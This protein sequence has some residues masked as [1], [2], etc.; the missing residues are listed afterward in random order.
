[1]VG[2]DNPKNSKS[3]KTTRT[4][5]DI[6]EALKELG[7]VGVT[8]LAEHLELPKSTV[9]IHL[10]TLESKEYVVNDNGRYAIGCRFLEFGAK[11]RQRQEIYEVSKP[12][13]DTL[14]EETGE[15]SGLVIEEHGRA[16]FLYRAK[17]EQAVHLDTYAGRRMY[18]HTAALGKAML[19]HLPSSRV[20]EILE[21]HG[22]PEMTENTITERD[23]LFEELESIRKNGIAFADEERVPKLRSVAAPIMDNNETVLGAISVAGPT[24]RLEKE[25]FEEYFPKKVQSAVDVI[26]LNLAYS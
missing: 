9:H 12:E 26:E 8:E 22:L 4:T 24:S 3:L 18:L 21:Q 6:I 25:Q 16:V 20:E 10:S 17:G 5:L 2:T 23:K 14:A 11:A 1:M 13:V 19:A 7:K 15:V